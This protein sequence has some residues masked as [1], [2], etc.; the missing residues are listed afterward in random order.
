MG[1]LK[2]TAEKEN[3][4]RQSLR[5]EKTNKDKG[6]GALTIVLVSG[7][8]GRVQELSH[9]RLINSPCLVH[10]V[11]ENVARIYILVGAKY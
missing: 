6:K 8:P 2:R 10:H 7:K 11:I 3:I 4:S 1:V 9:T 5:R